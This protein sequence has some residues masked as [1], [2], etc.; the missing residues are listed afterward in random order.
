MSLGEY[1]ENWFSF[2]LG[3]FKMGFGVEPRPFKFDYS[4]TKDSHV[5]KLRLGPELKKEDLKVRLIKGG[6]LQIE[7]PREREVEGEEIKVE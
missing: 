5:L 6:V 4:R 2:K 1:E 3:P 7:W